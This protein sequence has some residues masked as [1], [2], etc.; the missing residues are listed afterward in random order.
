VEDLGK[1]VPEDELLSIFDPFVRS[2]TSEGEGYGLGLAIT[3]SAVQAHGGTVNAE[4]MAQGGFRIQI[5][6]PIPA[7][8]TEFY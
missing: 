4:N 8:K 3:L 6:L 1:G 2:T 5:S 7:T